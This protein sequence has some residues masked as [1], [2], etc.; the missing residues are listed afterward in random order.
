MLLRLAAAAAI[1]GLCTAA[2][3]AEGPYEPAWAVQSG[4]DVYDIA[5]RVAIDGAGNV[6]LIGRV[7]DGYS[8]LP[9][10]LDVLVEKYDTGGQLLWTRQL[11]TSVF[12]GSYSLA[13]DPAGS[14]YVGGGTDGRLG[15]SHVGGRDAF[16]TKYDSDGT[17]QWTRQFGTSA[18]DSISGVA[19][20]AGGNVIVA[21][22]TGGTI[23]DVSAGGSDLFLASYDGDGSLQWMRQVGT[24][25]DEIG[26]VMRLDAAG[27][28][29]VFGQCDDN[30]DRTVGLSS[31]C[32]FLA[33]YDPVGT[34]QWRLDFDHASFGEGARMA[35]DA[36]G[37]AWITGV[38]NTAIAQPYGGGSDAFVSR[39]SPDGEWLWTRL[40]GTEL[41]E[42]ALSVVPD[43]S[44]GA[45]LCGLADGNPDPELTW[46]AFFAKCD[47][48]GNWLWSSMLDPG[49]T[50][51]SDVALDA[52]GDLLL[53]GFSCESLFATNPNP[54]WGDVIVAKYTAPEPGVLALL[55][56]GTA[57]MLSLRYPA[58][59]R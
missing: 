4:R 41:A 39:Y 57:A 45:Y 2:T 16:L 7:S 25:S 14:L 50:V 47:A 33:K 24:P 23:G 43:D 28:I 27:N 59:A 17:L 18:S 40:W 1:F 8:G 13:F 34:L 5:A 3:L 53:T 55:A 58:R 49:E 44:G 20:D 54:G 37:Y 31:D 26:A 29:Y 30:A 46:R 48:E 15:Y 12:D 11:G 36:A 56:I 9:N 10:D 35:V 52:E 32:D 38:A 6:G 51:W 19:V 42:M 22:S 21:G